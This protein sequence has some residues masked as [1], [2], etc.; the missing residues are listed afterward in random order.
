MLKNLD[1]DTSTESEKEE[2]FQVP[3]FIVVNFYRMYKRNFTSAK[4]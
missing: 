4:F 1:P 3:D 2:Q